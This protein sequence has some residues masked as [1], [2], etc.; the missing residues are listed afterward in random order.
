M[1]WDIYQQLVFF[2]KK[3]GDL[4][5][6]TFGDFDVDEPHGHGGQPWTHQGKHGYIQAGWW[7]SRVYTLSCVYTL[8]F[9]SIF[10]SF[11]SSGNRTQHSRDNFRIGRH[12]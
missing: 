2:L 1:Y 10:N 6:H 9:L 8:G 5:A 4:S 7:H 12:E 3:I 11:I